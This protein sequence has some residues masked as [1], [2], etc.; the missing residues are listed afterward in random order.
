MQFSTI[1][2]IAL[3]AAV[4]SAA[5]SSSDDITYVDVTTTPKVTVS[6]VSTVKSTSTPL[7]TT[8]Y[9]NKVTSANTTIHNTFS[10]FYASISVN[11]TSPTVQAHEGA[12]PV[13]TYG[14]GALVGALAIALL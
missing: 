4:A 14:M 11:S 7:T 9:S 8:T 12:A 3:T 2:T 10:T 5:S 1:A 13:K 6:A